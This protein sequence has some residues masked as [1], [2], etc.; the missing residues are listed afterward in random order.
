MRLV[1]VL[2]VLAALAAAQPCGSYVVRCAAEGQ[3]CTAAATGVGPSVNPAVCPV[4]D[5]GGGG[6]PPTCFGCQAGLYCL[7]G[8]CTPIEGKSCSV[9]AD[10]ASFVPEIYGRP[11][12]CTGIS[13]VRLPVNI[14]ARG[15][16]CTFDAECL[17]PMTCDAG[18][19]NLTTTCTAS[20]QCLHTEYCSGGACVPRVSTNGAC[21][22]DPDNACRHGLTCSNGLCQA[23]FSR[24]VGEDCS[25]PTAQSL[26]CLSGRQCAQ[27]NGTYECSIYANVVGDA[28]VADLPGE[29]A[30]EAQKIAQCDC[31][32]ASG[33]GACYAVT[34]RAVCQV[35]WASL[36]SCA[37]QAQCVWEEASPFARMYS[38]SCLFDRC[39]SEAAALASCL[40]APNDWISLSCGTVDGLREAAGLAPLG[41][42][43]YDSGSG[44]LPRTDGAASALSSPLFLIF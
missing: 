3:P 11:L 1:V 5:G 26:A 42:S 25:A 10:C 27:V 17:G 39:A 36:T 12:V 37:T 16:N 2:L 19:C 31:S 15:D 6:N 9:D 35:Q 38:G 22:A 40:D 14:Y 33:A 32:L 29:C 20:T 44:L 24:E 13:C 28:C 21:S 43:D 7:A 4:G 41:V 23:V 18:K 30:P 8:T 34:P